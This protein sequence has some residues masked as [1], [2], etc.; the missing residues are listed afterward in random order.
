MCVRYITLSRYVAPEIL[1]GE[2]YGKPVDMWSIGVIT[3]I[4]LGGYPPFHDDNQAKLYQKIKKGECERAKGRGACMHASA[5]KN[6]LIG[7]LLFACLFFFAVN[8]LLVLAVCCVPSKEYVC[9]TRPPHFF[10]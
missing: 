9:R 8:Y 10:V 6:T 3:Y 2:I 5:V 4:L 7:L 1:K